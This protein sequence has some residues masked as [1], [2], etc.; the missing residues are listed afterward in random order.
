M[1]VMM[2]RRL[3]SCGVPGSQCAGDPDVLMPAPTLRKERSYVLSQAQQ[4]PH[5]ALVSQL[6]WLAALRFSATRG[7]A[8]DLERPGTLRGV[9]DTRRLQR[10][11]ALHY[12][13]S[14]SSIR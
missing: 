13:E 8:A 7:Q 3:R 1:I 14:G 6:L 2:V 11:P 5:L 10:L 4:Q 12:V 9:C